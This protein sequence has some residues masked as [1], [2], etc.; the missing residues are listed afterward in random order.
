[1]KTVDIAV[2]SVTVAIKA[3]KLLLRDG[4]SAKVVKSVKNVGN[5]GCM[6][7]LRIKEADFFAAAAA[8]RR[9]EISYRLM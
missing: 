7:A 4:V 1:M 5:A 6:Y 3:R 9:A 2:E 8:L